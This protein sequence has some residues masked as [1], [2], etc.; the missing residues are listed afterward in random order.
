MATR[1]INPVDAFTP[2]S[3]DELRRLERYAT[4]THELFD[5][6]FI[7]Q[8]QVS[9]TLSGGSGL[10]LTTSFAGVQ[11]QELRGALMLLRPL[12]LQTEKAGFAQVQ[13]MMKR[14]ARGKGTPEGKQ[15]VA[16][17]K[18][19]T[20]ALNSIRRDPELVQLREQRV[21]A[22]G[23][24]LHERDVPPERIFDDFLYGL[25]FHEDEERIARIGDWLPSEI[26][27]FIFIGTVR[28]VARVY[29]AFA[30]TP[31]AILR[32]PSLHP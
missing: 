2:F 24:V 11:D 6:P 5:C 3:S 18:S 26:Q 30:G 31:R 32:E 22:A 7:Q 14:H 23:T 21:D 8:E 10:G 1:P 12:H 4:R 19:Y 16:A 15:A 28:R 13:A 29:T 17:V 27:R 9:L 20:K 25:Y